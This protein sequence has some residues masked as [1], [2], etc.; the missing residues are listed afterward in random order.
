[1]GCSQTSLV[2][3]A[4][5]LVSLTPHMGVAQGGSDTLHVPLGTTFAV[6]DD[7]HVETLIVAGTLEKVT[8]GALSIEAFTIQVTSTGTI[9]GHDGPR[10]DI[11]TGEIAQGVTG[12]DGGDI[13]LQADQILLEE[14][15]LVAAGSGGAGSSVL[16]SVSAVGGHGGRGGAVHLAASTVDIQGVVLPGAGG[17]GGEAWTAGDSTVPSLAAIGGDGGD[18]GT[19]TI[20]GVLYATTLYDAPAP[21]STVA[22]ELPSDAACT[23]VIS[24]TSSAGCLPPPLPCE[25][26]DPRDLIPDDPT[27]LV[28]G[29]TGTP[30]GV[31]VGCADPQGPPGQPNALGDGGDGGDGC[32]AVEGNRGTD[33]ADG[34]SGTFGCSSGGNGGNGAGAATGSARG[35]EGGLGMRNGGSGGSATSDASAGDGGNGGSGGSATIGPDCAGGNGGNG[36]SAT[37]GS[38]TGGNGGHGLCGAGGSGGGASAGATAGRGGSG[39]S[40]SPSGLTGV[41]GTA[42]DGAALAGSGGA[43]LEV[44]P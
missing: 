15:S 6:E 4:L 10:A 7:L 9:Q 25:A 32:T 22:C 2:L 23:T 40:G 26:Q 33:G 14:D 19:V 17:N 43:G 1:M 36:G 31:G 28:P 37:A 27:V 8:P 20:N 18:S 5:L 21:V 11:G 3:S 41:S 24:G 38:A 30:G 39:G 42:Q 13:L 35:G 44:C 12:P 29:L 16:A 34:N